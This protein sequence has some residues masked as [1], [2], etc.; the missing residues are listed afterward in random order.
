MSRS[1]RWHR[2]QDMRRCPEGRRWWRFVSFQRLPASTPAGIVVVVSAAAAA[3]TATAVVVV[4]V[5]PV[6]RVVV[7]AGGRRGRGGGGGHRRGSDL[8]G[9]RRRRD[10]LALRCERGY[11]QAGAAADRHGQNARASEADHLVEH[12]H[13]LS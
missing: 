3:A 4:V 5:I 11:L 13:F 9:D 6:E 7:S 8:R 10:S 1:V 2:R 12:F